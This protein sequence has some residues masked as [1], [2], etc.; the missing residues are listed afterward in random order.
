[1]KRILSFLSLGVSLLFSCTGP[2]ETGI[3][4]YNQFKEEKNITG[5]EV[6]LDSVFY[7]YLYR[8]A[9]KENMAILMDLHPNE[10]F[11]HVYSYPDWQFI[12]SFGKRGEGPEEVLSADGVRFHSPDSIY[13]LDANRMIVTRWTLS[14][15][16]KI[17]SR[18][19][20]IPLNKS[21]IRSL[22]FY[23][24]DKN[25]LIPNYSGECRY[26]EVS[27]DGQSIQDIGEIPT[28]EHKE[29]RNVALAQ[30]WRTFTDYNPKNNIY[31]L[32][33]Q[34]GEVVEIHNL[35]TG[36]QIVLYGPAG[37]PRYKE[38]KGESFPNGIKGFTDVQVTDKYIYALFDGMSWEERHQYY[39]RGEEAPNGGHFIYMFDLKGKPIR[40]YILDKNIM[41]FEID[42]KRNLLIATCAESDE[43]II[44]YN[45]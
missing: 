11:Y 34:L 42:E 40:K 30:A 23:R 27:H 24:T 43:P 39:K 14:P 29:N 9:I 17:V 45:L 2:S 33:T 6:S 18:V 12:A 20:D 13:T 44:L 25:F 36:K 15:E 3:S 19:E 38:H 8:V 16:A 22:D 1:M 32:V 21:L 5:Q 26:H 31:A 37:E 28:E 10:Y 41:G 35:K 7:R 4:H